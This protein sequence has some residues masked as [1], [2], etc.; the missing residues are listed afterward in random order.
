MQ[1]Q[2]SKLDPQNSCKERA[3]FTKMFHDFQYTLSNSYPHRHFPLHDDDDGSNDDNN[4]DED[5]KYDYDEDEDEN[6]IF[7]ASINGAG[8]VAKW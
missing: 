8:D 6:Y 4:D 1:F 3:S 5:N 7:K 2:P